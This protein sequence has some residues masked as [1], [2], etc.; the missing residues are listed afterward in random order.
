[1]IVKN[2]SVSYNL[3][4]ILMTNKI[5]LLGLLFG[6]I[7]GGCKKDNTYNIPASLQ[8][9]IDNFIAEAA[10]RGV[11][12][13]I[14]DLIIIFEDNLEVDG[15]EAAGICARSR[16]TPEI[17]LDTTSINWRINLSSR[18]Q[19]VFHELGHCVL[20]RSHISQKLNN[21]NYK[22]LMR[23]SGEQIY[24]PL[25]SK[26][27]R[28]Y[29]LDELFNEATPSPEWADNVLAYNSSFTRVSVFE[30]DFN[31]DD[32]NW[33]TGVS[34]RTS[35]KIE[36]G[37]YR[38]NILQQGAYFV[39]RDVVMDTEKDFEIEAKVKLIG[40]DGFSG[41]LWGGDAASVG[42]PSYK[43]M[44][45]GSGVISIGSI[46]NGTESTNES[47]QTLE[48]FNTITLRKIGN[49]LIYYL[50]GDILN[51]MRIDE[52][53]GEKIG[54]PFGGG[55]NVEVQVDEFDIYYLE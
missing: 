52:S 36:S 28:V 1:M 15:V 4:N 50:N 3:K 9:Y 20:E 12:L 29:Y 33:S 48:G 24:G 17:K 14:E 30:E 42:T 37:V 49:E 31:S 45:F 23:P 10:T 26:F 35:R 44:Y 7:L 51:N 16:S 11:D 21:G 22:T 18:E 5:L 13:K 47:A 6:F 19:L 43:S 53:I 38:M 25:Y 46:L 2:I 39:G 55:T 34:S 8:P 54:I 40:T 41:I 27:K 32:G